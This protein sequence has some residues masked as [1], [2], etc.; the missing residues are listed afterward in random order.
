MRLKEAWCQK[1]GEAT[2]ECRCRW[3]QKGIN[4]RNS[5]TGYRNNITII[6]LFYHY[7]EQ[8]ADGFGGKVLPPRHEL[9]LLEGGRGGNQCI[10]YHTDNGPKWDFN[11]GS[12]TAGMTSM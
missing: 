8:M 5:N 4:V 2:W 12:L 9:A 6:L 10:L 1:N 11:P 3:A 7:S